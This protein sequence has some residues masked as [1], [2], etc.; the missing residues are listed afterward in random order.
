MWTHKEECKEVIQD[1][2]N[3]YLDTST[4]EGLA[5]SLRKCAANLS[6]WSHSV[7][8]HIP[9]QI[10]AKRTALQ[11]LV[12]RDSDCNHGAEINS[13]RKDIN[14]LLDSEEIY[15][16]QRSRFQ[17]LKEEDC[18]TKFFHFRALERK[19]KNTILGLGDDNGT[20]YDTLLMSLSNISRISIHHPSYLSLMM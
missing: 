13:L 4:P 7:F 9:K 12:I 2:W 18:N 11:S 16:N 17:W 14:D 10:Q 1:A 20:W 3:A 19:S 6:S 8:G 5:L 15:W